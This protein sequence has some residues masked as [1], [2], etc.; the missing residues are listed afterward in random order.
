MRHALNVNNLI[1]F[2]KNKKLDKKLNVVI[3]NKLDH[4]YLAPIVANLLIVKIFIMAKFK[5]VIIVLSYFNL[6][7]VLM[8]VESIF[9]Q[10][11]N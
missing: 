9:I 7:C 4:L 5:I 6:L 1:I 11:N 3:V 10:D 8:D 2:L